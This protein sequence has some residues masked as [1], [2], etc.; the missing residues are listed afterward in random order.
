MWDRL[1]SW[2]FASVIIVLV[3]LGQLLHHYHWVVAADGMY[4]LAVVV[5]ILMAVH[6]FYLKMQK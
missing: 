6:Y 4:I 3:E 1:K 2:M 5:L